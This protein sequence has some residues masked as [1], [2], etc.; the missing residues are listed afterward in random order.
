MTRRIAGPEPIPR[1]RFAATADLADA[2]GRWQ[3]WLADERR[4]SP[5]T[6]AAY[7]RDLA[8]F[9]DFIA[10]RTC[11]PPSLAVLEA[12]APA[13]FR[14]YLV[15]L[16]NRLQASSRARVLSVLRNFFRFLARRDLAHN[17]AL[18]AIHPPKQPKL[19]P[20]A[21]TIEDAAAVLT[22]AA[23]DGARPPW[24]A[25]RDVAILTLLYGCGLRIA[26]ALGLTRAQAPLEPG[27]LTVTGKG[28]KSRIVP[29]LPAVAEAVSDYLAACPFE[30][31]PGA[32][33]FVGTGGGPLNPRL[34]QRRVRELRI[35][36]GLPA[37]VTPHALRHSFATH[38]MAGGGDLRVIKDLLDHASISTTARYLAVD[39][40]RLIAVF[41]SAHP[42]A[43]LPI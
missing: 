36:L 34:V 3:S 7:G 24:L 43:K 17:A 30:L 21:L 29:V 32:P 15:S 4:Y 35:G 5:H 27:A 18:S 20:R 19:V 33:L 41:E 8:A 12:L 6:L 28:D 23:V 26:E 37:T 1:W 38:L 13:D 10:S 39:A 16:S 2:I 25:K 11:A 9:L 40:T 31:A 22:A 42:R 14:A